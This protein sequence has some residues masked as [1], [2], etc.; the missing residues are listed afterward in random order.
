M[1]TSYKTVQ[2]TARLRALY[3]GVSESSSTYDSNDWQLIPDHNDQADPKIQQSGGED[4][5][6]D[7]QEVINFIPI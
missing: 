3:A 6:D 1:A 5:E 2:V 7:E 4:T